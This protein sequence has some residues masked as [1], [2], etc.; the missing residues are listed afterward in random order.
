ML[1][2]AVQFFSE[3]IFHRD[4]A[5][6]IVFTTVMVAKGV[7]VIQIIF[8]LLYSNDPLFICISHKVIIDDL[9]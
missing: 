1:S 7:K 6:N 3:A 9:M 2:I 4:V 8:M 5:T